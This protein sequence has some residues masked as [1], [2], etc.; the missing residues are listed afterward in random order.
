MHAAD[1]SSSK[2]VNENFTSAARKLTSLS[3]F[4][5]QDIF[6]PR[7]ER[8]SEGGLG[9]RGWGSS[10]PWRTAP[11]RRARLS[12]QRKHKRREKRP[13]AKSKRRNAQTGNGE[14]WRRCCGP[15][16][17]SILAVLAR[18]A[19]LAIKTEKRPRPPH[20]FCRPGSLWPRPW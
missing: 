11:S 9:I 3:G 16:A 7:L 8:A 4:R 10:I 17:E 5:G 15:T 18:L 19:T 6:D 13:L 20:S 14:S 1:Q 12:A 2:S